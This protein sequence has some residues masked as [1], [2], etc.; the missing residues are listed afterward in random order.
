VAR[1][2][3][4]DG[5]S[6]SLFPFL[7]VLA[8][9]IGTLTL[10]LAALALGQMGGTSLDQVRL[11]D[12]F[13]ALQDSISRARERLEELDRAMDEALALEA[14][15]E[16][17]RQRLAGL[18]F[19]QDISLEDLKAAAELRRELEG[20]ARRQREA[21]RE[22]ERLT[23][24]IETRERETEQRGTL[25]KSAPIVIDPSGLGRDLHPYLVECA[26]GRVEIH[27]TRDGWSYG[28]PEAEILLDSDFAVFLRRVRSIHNGIVIFLIREQ[29]IDTYRL[30]SE[31]ADR[32]NV[33]YAK[34]PIPGDGELDFSLSN[35]LHTEE[36]KP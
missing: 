23:A 18:G 11:M 25:E 6:G 24:V 22:G 29:G 33:R 27:R 35:Q 1:R 14:Q 2:R 34:L 4:R 26:A 21:E 8:C 7:S 31:A 15:D 30:A 28:I 13:E 12:R 9:V 17:L 16:K 19:S 32:Q 36:E 5:P 20:L 10:S 3:R